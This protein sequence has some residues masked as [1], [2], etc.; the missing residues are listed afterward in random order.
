MQVLCCV[1]RFQLPDNTED[2]QDTQKQD[3]ETRLAAKYPALEFP[4]FSCIIIYL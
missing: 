1:L 4:F 2:A 3:K